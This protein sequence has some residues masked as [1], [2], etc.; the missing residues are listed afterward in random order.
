MK[1]LCCESVRVKLNVL[2]TTYLISIMVGEKTTCP[3]QTKLGRAFWKA[4]GEVVKSNAAMD[5]LSSTRSN[6]VYHFDSE[7]VDSAMVT[8]RQLW[9]QTLL[10]VRAKEY[11]SARQS[12]GQL[13]HSLQVQRDTAIKAQIQKKPYLTM[14]ITVNLE[15]RRFEWE[16]LL[17][18][19]QVLLLI[20]KPNNV[21]A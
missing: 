4:V 9:V 10:S 1:Q 14:T 20:L 3:L 17:F 11:Q 21:S 19:R 6:P 16:R 2:R 5:F 7:Q 13:F 15:N 18:N 12:L 8:V